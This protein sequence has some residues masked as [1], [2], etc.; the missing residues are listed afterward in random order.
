MHR[1]PDSAGLWTGGDAFAQAAIGHRRLSVIAPGP[2]GAQ[3]MVSPDGRF[4]L[5]Y[6]GELYNDAEVRGDLRAAG[7][8]V[9]SASDTET[10]LLALATWGA[11][12]L[13]RLRGMY[14]L[15]FWDTVGRR[16]LLAR[17]PL[18][19]KPLHYA[20]IENRGL[21]FASEPAAIF[22][23]GAVLPRPDHAVMSAYMTTVRLTQGERTLFDGVRT[24]LPGQVLEVEVHGDGIECRLSFVSAQPSGA[25][26]DLR[27]VIEGSVLTHLRSNVPMCSL[28]SGGIDSSVVASV[29]MDRLGRLDTYCSGA[30]VDGAE[31]D[32]FAHARTVAGFIGSR[33]VEAPVDRP[34][35]LGRWQELVRAMGT[36]LSTPNEVAINEVARTLRADGKVVTLSGEGA[37]ELLGGYELPMAAVAEHVGSTPAEADAD[38]GGGGFQVRA[39]AWVIGDL[40]R[41]LM[42]EAFAA[43]AGDDGLLFEVAGGLYRRLADEVGSAFPDAN[44]HERRMQTHLRYQR[45]VNLEGLLRRLDSATMRASVE[46]RTPFADARVMAVCESLPMSEKYRHGENGRGRATKVA[47]REAFRGRLPAAVVERPKASFPLPFESWVDGA[48]DVLLGSSFAA[49]TFNPSALVQIAEQPGRHWNLAWPMMNLAMW[50]ER[51]WG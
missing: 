48:R 51:W 40:K 10:V 41:M 7:V 9:R 30:V 47:L 31:G 45:A 42:G 2:E 35:F 27:A 14:G 49:E 32:D 23:H 28:L 12:G 38:G 37:D 39:N 19:I 3:P 16:L 46:G 18:G 50:G 21:L 4:V 1:G 25:S 29:A 43:G 5:S 34:M 8:G 26:G 13:G 20:M 44:D 22:E 15:A 11:A 36:P 17:D 6:N 33:H 24:L